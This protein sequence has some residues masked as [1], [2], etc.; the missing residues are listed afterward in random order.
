M[1]WNSEIRA[2]TTGGTVLS[3]VMH[4]S[5]YDLLEIIICAV[6]GAIVSYLVTVLLK[7]IFKSRY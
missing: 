1:V 3:T 5:G 2:G 4:L 7:K 6:I